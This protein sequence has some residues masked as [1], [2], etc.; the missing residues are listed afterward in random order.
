MRTRLASLIISAAILGACGGDSTAPLKTTDAAAAAQTFAQLADSVARNGGSAE[1]G[2]AYAGIAGILRMGGRVTPITLTIDGASRSYLATAMSIESVTNPCPPNAMC[3][4]PVMRIVQRSLI[5]WDRDN[6]TRI[7]QLSSSSNDERIGTYGDSTSLA[8]W[9]PL[10]S[11][12]YMDGTGVMYFGTSGE[13]TF[14]VSKSATPCPTS[15]DTI[16]LG[17]LRPRGYSATCVLADI[18]VKFDGTVEPSVFVAA[19]KTAVTHTIAM[20]T[21][22]VA[23]THQE[24]SVAACDT[25]CS[26]PP[27]DPN[28]PTPTPPVVVSPGASLPASLAATVDSLVHLVFTVKNASG[29]PIRISFP[30]SQRFDIVAIDSTTGK[31]VWT[32]SA[33][34]SFLATAQ[35]ETVPGNGALVY[36]ASWKPPA[37]GLY[38][39]HA[40]L[41]STSPRAEAYTT[42]VVP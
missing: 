32:W 42:V 1:A 5:A 19:N 22:T 8:L 25:S 33:N 30:S 34:Q 36:T 26:V 31:N 4:A 7:V 14:A 15:A 24:T 3:F 28:G 16:P 20:G 18:T 6:P 12:I 27:T 41:A 29:A 9:A 10:A 23:G 39:F 40:T 35:D 2:T 21:Q 11:L 13:Q 38:L 37:K 17:V